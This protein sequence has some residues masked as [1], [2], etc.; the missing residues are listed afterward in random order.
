MGNAYYILYFFKGGRFYWSR[1]EMVV[2]RFSVDV[3][4]DASSITVLFIP[5]A[6]PSRLKSTTSL[7]SQLPPAF[8]ENSKEI[9]TFSLSS[10]NA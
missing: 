5:P 3:E 6:F 1:G 10:K 8:K 4:R 9:F 2:N 7:Y